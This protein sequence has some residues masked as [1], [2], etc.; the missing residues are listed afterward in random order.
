MLKVLVEDI[1]YSYTYAEVVGIT[2]AYFLV[3]YLGL[4]PLFLWVC[5]LLWKKGHLQ[6]IISRKANPQQ[7][8][9]EIGH[10]LKSVF[11]FG[12][13]AIPMV[14]MIREGWVILLPNTFGYII[15]GLIIL[16]IW[17]EIHF[18]TIHRLMHIPFFMKRVHYVHHRSI[19]PTVYSVYSFHGLEAF[20]LSTVPLTI[21]PWVPFSPMAIFLYPLVS[22]LLNFCG[23]CN[24]RF[25]NGT[26]AGWKILSTR[27]AEHHRKG[28]KNY[29]FASPILDNLTALNTSKPKSNV[30]NKE[31]QPNA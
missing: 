30:S 19:T 3:L 13:S 9:F 29:G 27:H 7:I 11:I 26:G 23:H 21:A 5:K 12:L 20:L 15:L 10:S 4:A 28:R 6:Q 22:I 16:S 2:I 8:R 24:Y 31:Q 17:N 1:I 14:W 25:G 18:F